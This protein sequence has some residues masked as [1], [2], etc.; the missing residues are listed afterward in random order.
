MP[1]VISYT[2][3]WLSRPEPGFDLFTSSQG[4]L[5]SPQRERRGSGQQSNGDMS[6]QYLGPKK[7]IA[8]RGTEVFVV[9]DNQI[10]WSDLCLLKDDY[11]EREEVGQ[12][13]LHRRTSGQSAEN[14]G[15]SSGKLDQTSS[16]RVNFEYSNIPVFAYYG[17]GASSQ[18]IREN[19]A[20]TYFA[21]WTSPRHRYLPYYPYRHP[22]K[23][24]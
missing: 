22:P 23:P 4:T 16:Y 20:T 14:G 8:Q 10:R 7:I 11:D 1:K 17:G 5:S 24:F 2:P 21:K 18:H 13:A 9:A 15:T 12:K 19:T 6:K 3:P